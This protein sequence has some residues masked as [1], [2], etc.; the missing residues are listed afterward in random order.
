MAAA[1][2]GVIVVE[3]AGALCAGLCGGLLAELGA[4]VI[5]VER[6]GTPGVHAPASSS[7][8]L[9]LNQCSARRGQG[10]GKVCG[11]SLE[12]SSEPHCPHGLTAHGLTA[13]YKTFVKR[14]TLCALGRGGELGERVCT[15][16]DAV[17]ASRA[18]RADACSAAP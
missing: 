4:R 15:R 14:I 7:G 18:A 6:A 16:C 13:P 8:R 3:Q 2:H 9:G 5:R 12:F 11:A 10:V 1:L 17:W